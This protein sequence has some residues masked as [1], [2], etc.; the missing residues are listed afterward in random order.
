[1]AFGETQRKV[2]ARLMVS[3]RAK[4]RALLVELKKSN[5]PDLRDISQGE[6]KKKKKKGNRDSSVIEY[7]ILDALVSTEAAFMATIGAMTT[8]RLMSRYKQPF[9]TPHL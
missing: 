3:L 1:M 7:W 8:E 4:K 9:V 5:D 2:I 6:E